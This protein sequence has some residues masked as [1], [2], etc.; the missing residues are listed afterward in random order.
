MVGDEASQLEGI[1]LGGGG[2]GEGGRFR[3]L[4]L[5]FR[6]VAMRDVIEQ[7]FMLCVNTR[8]HNVER[9]APFN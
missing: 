1:I 8:D 6:C 2:G 9:S 4:Q 3:D 5:R 7:P